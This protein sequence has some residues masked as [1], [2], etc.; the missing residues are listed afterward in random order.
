VVLGSQGYQ[1]PHMH[2]GAWISGVYYVSLPTD[3]GKSEDGQ[4]G[5]LEFGRCN[6]IFRLQRPPRL[7]A[8]RPEEG[9]L[10]L[11]PSF[12]WHG[13][14]PFESA[15]PRISIAFDVLASADVSFGFS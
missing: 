1:E 12:F 8:V 3:V 4:A 5:W 7:H 11:F 10:V 15:A 9:L 14:V 6:D 13:T 2:D